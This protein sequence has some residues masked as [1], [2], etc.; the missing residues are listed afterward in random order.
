MDI[1]SYYLLSNIIAV[2]V[3][4]EKYAYVAVQN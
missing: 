3:Y 1:N 2:K 4:Y